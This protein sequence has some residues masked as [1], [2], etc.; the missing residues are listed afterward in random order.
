MSS[1]VRWMA[2]KM[3][4]Q[5]ELNYALGSLEDGALVKHVLDLPMARDGVAVETRLGCKSGR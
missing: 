3:S 5:N 4:R 2:V 1:S